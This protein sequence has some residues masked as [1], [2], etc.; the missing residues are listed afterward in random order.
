MNTV[1]RKLMVHWTK[2]VKLMD[3][4]RFSDKNR[5]EQKQFNLGWKWKQSPTVTG[6]LILW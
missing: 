4:G 3:N 6:F 2:I 1:S 5:H